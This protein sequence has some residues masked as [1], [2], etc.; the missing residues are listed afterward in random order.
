MQL[1]RWPTRLVLPVILAGVAACSAPGFAP[2]VALDARSERRALCITS[3]VGAKFNLQ[4]MGMTV[5]GND[6][7]EASIGAWGL[8][9]AVTAKL[10]SLAGG[11][12]QVQRIA[13]SQDVV[14]RFNDRP[15]P[16]EDGRVPQAAALRQ[17]VVGRNCDLLLVVSNGF[18]PI[19][20]S[21]QSIEGIGVFHVS[22]PLVSKHWLHTLMAI[23]LYD[24]RTMEAINVKSATNGQDTFMSTIKGPHR[25]VDQAWWVEPAQV[26]G[27]AR[28]RAAVRD[29]VEQALVT[30]LPEVLKAQPGPITASIPGTPKPVVAKMSAKPISQGGGAR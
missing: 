6:H 3:V 28:L 14:A 11:S 19:G 10:A 1:P 20:N 9:D 30:T 12:A 5:F 23:S 17:L 27:D 16:F 15:K 7:K 22:T 29:M 18:S 2:P 21:N 13:A 26:A 8:D 24:A 4:T 25:E